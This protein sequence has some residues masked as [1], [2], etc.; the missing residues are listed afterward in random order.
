MTGFAALLLLAI[1][2]GEVRAQSEFTFKR[3]DVTDGMA[4]NYVVDITQDEQEYIW[5]AS[6]SGLSRFD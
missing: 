5:I 2:N 3:L 1:G 6:E 4:S